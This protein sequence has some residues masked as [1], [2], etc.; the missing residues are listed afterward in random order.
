[1]LLACCNATNT[2]AVQHANSTHTPQDRH[3]TRQKPRTP[4]ATFVRIVTPIA[5]EDGRVSP[6][7][8]EMKELKA[9]KYSIASSWSFIS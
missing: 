6:K 5:P 9:N 8:V 7:H 3:L 1:M 2:V 4:Y